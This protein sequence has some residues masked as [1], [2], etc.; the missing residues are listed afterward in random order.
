MCNSSTST[1][2]RDYKACIVKT[3]DLHP[4]EKQQILQY[5][6]DKCQETTLQ[7]NPCSDWCMHRVLRTEADCNDV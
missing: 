1:N 5:L 2:T 3:W 4:D 6:T 7:G